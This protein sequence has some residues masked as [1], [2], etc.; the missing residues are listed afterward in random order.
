MTK[1]DSFLRDVLVRVFFTNLRSIETICYRQDIIKDCLE[2]PEIIRTMYKISVQSVLR[3]QHYGLGIYSKSPTGILHDSVSLLNLFLV[4]LK[5]LRS[6]SSEF[7][8]KFKS[9]GFQR[10]FSRFGSEID[11]NFIQKFEEILLGLRFPNGVLLS[12]QLGKANQ[13]K[14][15][16]LRKNELTQQSWVKKVFSSDNSYSFTVDPKD[17][18]SSQRLRDLRDIGFNH[19]LDAVAQSA[20]HIDNFFNSLRIELA[21]YMCCLNLHDNLEEIGASISFPNPMPS[22]ERIHSFTGLYDLSL[23][24]FTQKKAV[25]NN[26]DLNKKN[27]IMITGANQG[28]KSTFLRSIGIAQLLM[29]CGMFVPADSFTANLSSGIYTHFKREEDTNMRSGKFDEE[30]KRMSNIINNITSNSLLLLNES[31]ASTNELEGTEIADQITR[32]LLESHIKVF[33][34]THLYS[35]ADKYFSRN[36]EDYL[37]LRAPRESDGSRTFKLI[38]EKPL[39][40]SFGED[41]YHEI[42]STKN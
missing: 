26:L 10:F 36:K 27:L 22:N 20:E 8:S 3:K 14:N 21:F 29:Q 30:L 40:T 4:L 2:Q 39:K 41:I 32:A 24:L 33:F 42:F 35:L 11:D 18:P 17:K 13:G 23:S 25:A 19:I 5:K 1:N 12:A 15:Y 9:E 16:I 34:V 28:G 31:F 38:I 6:I 37:F 7:G